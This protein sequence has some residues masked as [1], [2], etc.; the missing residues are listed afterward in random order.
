MRKNRKMEHRMMT[1]QAIQNDTDDIQTRTVEGYAAVFN[2]ETLI[3]KSDYTGYEYRE[4]ILPGAFDNTDFSQLN[5]M[6]FAFIVNGE[7]EEIDREN[8]VYTRKIKSV[9]A[10]YDVSIV[11]NPAY[12]G[13]SVSARANGDYERYEDIEKRKRLTLLAMT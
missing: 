6:S 10:V 11:D 2:E 5:K 8:K 7:E 12:K 1:V 9:K 13:T 3:W 4:V